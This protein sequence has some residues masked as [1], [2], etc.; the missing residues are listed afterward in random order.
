M[1]GNWSDSLDHL[2]HLLVAFLLALPIGWNRA[3]AEQGAG[4]RTFPLVAM[5]SCGFVQTG[6]SVLGAGVVNQANIM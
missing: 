6:I 2:V 1:L 3:R 4:L 5:A